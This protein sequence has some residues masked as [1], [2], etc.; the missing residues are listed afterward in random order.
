ML[1]SFGFA[2]LLLVLF[3]GSAVAVAPIDIEVPPSRCEDGRSRDATGG[4]RVGDGIF[5]LPKSEVPKQETTQPT[6]P[7]SDLES[8]GS[9]RTQ[10][11][12]NNGLPDTSDSCDVP[13]NALPVCPKAQGRSRY[14]RS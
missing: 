7:R 8:R 2:G 3:S 12:Y 11:K 1:R 14:G 6:S 5:R 9:G 4:C 10:N 13:P